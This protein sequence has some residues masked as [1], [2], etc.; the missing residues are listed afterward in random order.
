MH[1]KFATDVSYL[2]EELLSLLAGDICDRT[3]RLSTTC[4][5]PTFHYISNP[6]NKENSGFDSQKYDCILQLH[7][8][9]ATI[10]AAFNLSLY[11]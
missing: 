3:G 11:V 9:I 6:C 4:L 10:S 5:R 7:A 8:P 1:R 2:N